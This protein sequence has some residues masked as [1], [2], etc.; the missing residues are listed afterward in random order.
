MDTQDV[1]AHFT[2]LITA[3]PQLFDV[4]QLDEET[5]RSLAV[6]ATGHFAAEPTR[7]RLKGPIIVVGDLHGHI[8]DLYRILGV[9]GLP[10]HQTYLFLGDLVDRGEYSVATVA[11]IYSMKI[12]FPN[13]V[14]IVRGNHES[15]DMARRSGLYQEVMTKYKSSDLY[16]T[17]LDS[18]E[19]L[20]LSASIGDRILCT[21][22]GIPKDLTSL[23]QLDSI[24]RPISA[25]SSDIFDGLTW[26][27]PSEDVEMFGESH[28]GRA[29]LFG[30]KA[31]EKFLCNTGVSL[32]IRG[33]ECVNDGIRYMFGDRLITV[34]S[35]SNYC[36][37]TDNKGAVLRIGENYEL[38][39][40]V[41]DVREDVKNGHATIVEHHKEQE[42]FSFSRRK[43]PTQRVPVIRSLTSLWGQKV[44][45]SS[46]GLTKGLVKPGAI[47][48]RVKRTFSTTPSPA[49]QFLL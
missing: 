20:P 31:F 23:S 30:E 36:G 29:H 37:Y 48:S 25:E 5:V 19:S 32:L 35:A 27:D 33:H 26:S 17:L 43:F 4:P 41:F 13:H 42:K 1:L 40:F 16:D 6:E 15:D 46:E 49:L 7:L 44:A 8:F 18:F 22:G 2:D 10:P 45:R 9:H 24:E 39:P 14:Y 12:L 47:V 3:V 38:K 21:H 28:R 34:F 11:L